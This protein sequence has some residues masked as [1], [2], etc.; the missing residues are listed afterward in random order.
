MTKPKISLNMGRL[1]AA[2]QQFA[3]RLRRRMVLPCAFLAGLLPVLLWLL[4]AVFWQELPAGVS[5]DARP[6]TLG[7]L[8]LSPFIAGFVHCRWQ[9]TAEIIAGALPAF[10]LWAAAI[11]CWRGLFGWPSL[12]K[13]LITLGICLLLGVAGGMSARR[14]EAVRMAKAQKNSTP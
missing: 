2:V 14:I 5:L 12:T 11:I 4:A 8:A 7:V 13:G 10:W 3:Y 6:L 9:P 1:N